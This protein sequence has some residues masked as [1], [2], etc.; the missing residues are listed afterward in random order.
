[1]AC[2]IAS[3]FVSGLV[4][5][6]IERSEK[7]IDNVSGLSKFAFDPLVGIVASGEE[8]KDAS[9][10]YF[11]TDVNI[12]IQSI[13]SKKLGN[14]NVPVYTASVTSSG[15]FKK[16]VLPLLNLTKGQIAEYQ[17]VLPAGSDIKTVSLTVN[18]T[19]FTDYRII[20]SDYFKSIV[21][22]ENK[23]RIILSLSLRTRQLV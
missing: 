3:L 17:F 15:T 16:D 12:D 20:S 23:V 9:Y 2:F 19:P 11:V 8:R 21:I 13:I 7:A 14:Q 6:R 5:D 4:S 22:S 1:M 18:G 10:G